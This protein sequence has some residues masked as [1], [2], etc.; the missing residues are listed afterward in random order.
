VGGGLLGVAARGGGGLRVLA[1]PAFLVI[2]ALLTH[3]S[4]L[5][6]RREP[7]ETKL[8]EAP[9]TLAFAGMVKEVRMTKIG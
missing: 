2:P 9:W 3:A 1:Y 6:Q 7:S 8:R 5:P 4:P